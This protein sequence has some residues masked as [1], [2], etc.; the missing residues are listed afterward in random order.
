MLRD[1]SSKAN[2]LSDTRQPSNG[3]D[4]E[5]FLSELQALY[6]APQI[7]QRL[8]QTGA[9]QVRLQLATRERQRAQAATPN[10]LRSLRPGARVSD[11]MGGS[12]RYA[13][14]SRSTAI[15]AVAAVALISLLAAALFARPGL[16]VS[17]TGGHERRTPPPTLPVSGQPVTL[18]SV[19]MVSANDGWAFGMTNGGACI[20][21]HYDGAKWAPRQGSACDAV[22]TLASVPVTS[23]AMLSANDGWAVC[24]D[25]I[26]HYTQGNWRVDTIYAPHGQAVWLQRVAMVS[27]DEGWAVGW[28]EATQQ[29]SILHYTHGHWTPTNIAG[30]AGV[31]ASGLRGIV[32]LSAREGWAVGSQ[33]FNSGYGEET[34]LVLHYINGQWTRIPWSMA[35][36][37]NSVAA[38]PS[39]D[40]WAVGEDNPATGPGLIVHLRN[41][42]PIQEDRPAPGLLHDI[43]MV[44]PSDGWAV[45]DGAATVRYHDGVWTREGLTI[46]QYSLGRV[47]LVSVTEGWAVGGAADYP[48]Q[49]PNASA[50][51]FHLSGGVWRIYPL[52]GV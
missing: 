45:G 49:D 3:A 42:V 48:S 47:S 41:G 27:P 6:H 23:I 44:S 4:D 13:S 31:T 50:P 22:A 46:H 21:L 18:T 7:P 33:F 5:R 40:V 43:A 17:T 19:A 36:S 37:F 51:L 25:T 20:V 30:M 29:A 28:T 38:F 52:S 16:F 15:A 32:M 1:P 14:P 11:H 24:Y 34:T 10:I 26:L 35:G 2:G 8:Q 9:E 39:G 12:G